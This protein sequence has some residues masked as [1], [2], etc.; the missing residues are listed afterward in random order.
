MV[1]HMPPGPSRGP[2]P[3]SRP[4]APRQYI[5]PPNP[6]KGTSQALIWNFMLPY[7]SEEG[8]RNVECCILVPSTDGVGMRKCG[9]TFKHTMGGSTTN[10][11]KHLRK[12][13]PEEA[14]KC[15]EGSKHSTLYKS[16][17]LDKEEPGK[18]PSS[19]KQ[20]AD[21]AAW[22]SAVDALVKS[23]E[24]PEVRSAADRSRAYSLFCAVDL[25]PYTL[26]SEPGYQT[27]LFPGAETVVTASHYDVVIADERRRVAYSVSKL[28]QAQQAFISNAPFCSLQID[29]CK[30]PGC[31]NTYAVA[32]VT[33]VSPAYEVCRV[34]LDV[35]SF[36]TQRLTAAELNTWILRV[37]EEYFN[38]LKPDQVFLTCTVGKGEHLK[39]AAGSLGIP[40]LR[41]AAELVSSVLTSGMTPSGPPSAKMGVTD[42]RN[43]V[44]EIASYLCQPSRRH[45]ELSALQEALGPQL[46]ALKPTGDPAHH[47]LY[48]SMAL[49]R[50]RSLVVKHFSGEV[51]F[52]PK[53]LSDQEWNKLCEVV[54]VLEA[55][56]EVDRT[57]RTSKV[58]SLT[59]TMVLL[60]ELREY[61]NDP[62]LYLPE[63]EHDLDEHRIEQ[64]ADQL[65]SALWHMRST[66]AAAL[67][68]HNVGAP[69]NKHERLAALLDVVHKETLLA[70]NDS[71]AWEELAMELSETRT[72]NGSGA[73]DTS[74][75][76]CNTDASPSYSPVPGISA[77][78]AGAGS[79]DKKRKWQ[80]ALSLRKEQRRKM[81]ES[82]IPVSS[83]SEIDTYKA[84]LKVY[85]ASS[86]DSDPGLLDWW[87][88]RSG[89][90]AEAAP[91][92]TS[93]TDCKPP[94]PQ[95][96]KLA[97]IAAQ[98]QS[99]DASSIQADA[100]LKGVEH[101]VPQLEATMS[102]N[103]IENMLF[104][105][106]N[107]NLVGK[108][109]K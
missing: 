80:G 50:M 103:T 108:Q 31:S 45:P 98:Y 7:S 38:C 16:K 106:L 82:S 48:L 60:R 96:P 25:H 5:A 91:P 94:V 27:F 43:R 23:S 63:P 59:E 46:R 58:A 79:C 44:Q 15:L 61:M 24:K 68:E 19:D 89:G 67:S 6:R 21:K 56:A 83:G 30:P 92:S 90:A 42:L 17:Q 10:L 49:L 64:R 12:K 36:P 29:T 51:T 32:T 2:V 88:E 26:S 100:L 40:I 72:R 1:P 74:S 107:R 14:R 8:S 84:S 33:Y 77:E 87:L 13:H 53:P 81:V 75:S 37:T 105:R 52:R 95:M 93:S 102:S 34:G 9:A 71:L 47:F 85:W 22:D 4:P 66:I 57:I 54:A 101:R 18:E 76:P 73:S 55:C 70:D 109:V 65:D 104:L 69:I 3:F 11:L 20:P 78:A 35:Q 28:L 86:G 41:C 39:E 97:Q 62:T 99:I